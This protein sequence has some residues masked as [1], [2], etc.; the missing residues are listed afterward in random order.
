MKLD[1]MEKLQLPEGFRKLIRLLR[2]GVIISQ[3]LYYVF[4]G[5]AVGA[6]IF[7]A[8]TAWAIAAFIMSFICRLN[9]VLHVGRR[10]ISALKIAENPEI[11]Y[12]GHSI[13]RQGQ[14]IDT[15]V[16]E[17]KNIKLHLKDGRQ[18]DV[19][20]VTGTGISQEQ[21][22]EIISWLRRHNPSIRWGDYDKPCFEK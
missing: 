12:W 1:R 2:R 4:L 15:L 8:G 14:A 13:N 19:D 7:H 20:A 16:V 6:L 11:V 18:L 5:C 22:R 17:S 10:Y 21:L 9:V 3:S